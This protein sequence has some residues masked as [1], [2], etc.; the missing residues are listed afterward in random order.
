MSDRK[1]VASLAILIL[2][3][4][5]FLPARGRA[6]ENPKPQAA[7]GEERLSQYVLGPGDEI[8][9]YAIDAEEIANKPIR[10]GSGGDITLPLVGRV[11]AAGLT[12]EQLTERL[13]AKLKVYIQEPQIAINITQFRSQP[14]S[15]IGCVNTSGVHQLE[16]RKSLI[17]VLSMA[18]GLRS[19]AGVMIK[20]TRR[21]EWGAIPL[22]S[23]MKDGNGFSIAE[24][25]YRKIV[26]ARNPEE[27]IRI[28][29]N[30]VIS[31]PR[32]KII[33]VVGNVHKPGGYAL[34]DH[35]SLSV[36]QVLALAEGLMPDSAP[37]SSKI[38]R[39]NAGSLRTEV[40]VNLKDIMAG[41]KSDVVLQAEDI[42]I[43]PGS[44][45][46]STIRRTFETAISL[47]AG[48]AIYRGW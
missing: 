1:T 27:N 40:A 28:L 17:E 6:Q 10:I 23:A 48:A 19:D 12:V 35:D 38:I 46:R 36:L 33:Y 32:A 31:V 8:V 7:Q 20:V 29:P 18:G 11:Q 24:V 37:G 2:A 42:L 30:D 26:D 25:D 9:I 13:R 15:V 39:T 14:V 41:K 16:G 22:P 43:V 47:A 44:Y 34:T 21:P 4:A 3:A 5:C 45:A